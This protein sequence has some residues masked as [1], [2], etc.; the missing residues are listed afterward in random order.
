M[1]QSTPPSEERSDIGCVDARRIC[2]CSQFQSTPPSEERSDIDKDIGLRA[3]VFQ[4]TPPSE[5]RSDAS[6]PD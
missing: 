6:V 3:E 5:E 2:G 4:S 1:F